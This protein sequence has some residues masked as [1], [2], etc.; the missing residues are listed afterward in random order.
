MEKPKIDPERGIELCIAKIDRASIQKSCVNYNK[1]KCHNYP[2]MKEIH[3]YKQ[4]DE[5]GKT[6]D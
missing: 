2:C 6:K 1:D 3:C 4:K 5:Y